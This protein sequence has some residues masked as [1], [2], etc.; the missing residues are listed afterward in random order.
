MVL[1]FSIL[2]LVILIWCYLLAS[3]T[4]FLVKLFFAA[5]FKLFSAAFASQLALA[6]A[7]LASFS[8]FL[9]KLFLAA[10]ASFLSV[11]LASHA[12][13]VA[14]AVWLNKNKASIAKV[15]FFIGHPRISLNKG[16]F[17]SSRILLAFKTRRQNKGS[18]MTLR[19]VAIPC[20]FYPLGYENPPGAKAN[21]A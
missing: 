18:R 17:Y 21:H 7:I 12:A 3:A 8:H 4:H 13:S 9:I 11:A 20:R 5:P 16:A 1:R 2:E 14:Y 19:R 15:S 10:P 6:P